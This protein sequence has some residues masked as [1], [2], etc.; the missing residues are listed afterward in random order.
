MFPTFEIKCLIHIDE[1]QIKDKNVKV[2]KILRKQHVSQGK[3]K[4][5][6][7]KKLLKNYINPLFLNLTFMKKLNPNFF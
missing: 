3:E 7:K 2:Y 4:L 6:V 1:I 5:F